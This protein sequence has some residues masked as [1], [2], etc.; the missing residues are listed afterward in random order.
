METKKKLIKKKNFSLKIE[1]KKT[2]PK[3]YHK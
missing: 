2:V 3:N 1:I